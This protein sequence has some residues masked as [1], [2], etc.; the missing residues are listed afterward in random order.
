[1]SA[2]TSDGMSASLRSALP[3]LFDCAV[4]RRGAVRVRTP[5]MYPDGGIVDVFAEDRGSG[6]LLSDYGE[7]L[8]WL[9]MQYFSDKLTT[10]QRSVVRDV[11]VTLGVDFV[12]GELT[13]ACDDVSAVSDAVHRLGRRWCACAASDSLRKV[14]H[15]P[16]LR[17]A[18]GDPEV[19]TT[20]IDTAASTLEKSGFFVR[21]VGEDGYKIPPS[22][23]SAQS[24]ERQARLFERGNRYQTRTAQTLVEKEFK[25]G[26]KT[27][28]VVLFPTR[29]RCG[30]RLAEN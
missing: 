27:L 1:M 25:H 28:P 16:E 21:K 17:F 6:C 9:R 3:A 4:T 2:M 19:E 12:D 23:D 14:A 20:S 24:R 10:H 5:F 29:R 8:G 22:G 7:A 26:E 13:L 30:R 11:C 18:L 15:L